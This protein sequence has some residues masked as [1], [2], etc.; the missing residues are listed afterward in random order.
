MRI[1]WVYHSLTWLVVWLALSYVSAGVFR[2]YPAYQL[3]ILTLLKVIG[4]A[5]GVYLQF[6]I[7]ERWFDSRQYRKYVFMVLLGFVVSVLVSFGI[8]YLFPILP[9]SWKQDAINMVALPPLALGIRYLKRGVVGQFQLQELRAKTAQ[10]EL[11]LL[12]AQIN[13]HFLFNT[14][15]NIYATN[16]ED[17]AK[18]SE[19]IMELADVMRYHLRSSKQEHVSLTE[20]VD[21]LKAYVA[22]EKLRLSENCLVT[23]EVEGEINEAKLPPLILL[24]YVEN[25]FKHGTHPTAS[26]FVTVR[27]HRQPESLQVLVENSIIAN[28]RTVKTHIGMKN[29][30]RR[31]QILYP[32]R[33]VLMVSEL[34][35]IF[36]VQLQL[37]L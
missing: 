11:N 18:G 15:N 35:G 4:F 7:K 27:I 6:Y 16:Q 24:P 21:L 30:A 23:F 22:L 14:L 36:R 5:V 2:E 32:K 37:P 29:V 31:L 13:P 34:P 12:K 1:R 25:A 19:M 3:Y 8:H 28:R 33:E 20:E 9:A 26:C 10:T 17:A